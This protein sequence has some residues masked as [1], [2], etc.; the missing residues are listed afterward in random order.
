MLSAGL[1]IIIE[2]GEWGLSIKKVSEALECSTQPI[3]WSFG[4]FEGYL[5]ELRKY[6]FEYMNGKMKNADGESFNHPSVGYQY[7]KTA[8]NEPNLIRYLRGNE[9]FLRKMGGIGGIFR[10]D[11]KSER[12]EYYSKEY[13]L[14]HENAEKLVNFFIIYTE[15]I[16]SLILSGVLPSDEEKAFSLLTE[17]AIGK[18]RELS[19]KE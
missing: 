16:V 14:S 8:V 10:E 6:A 5:T 1:K 3:S 19:G 13:S 9:A 15:G 7:I 17:A 11:V 18:I 2:E 12:T 4:N